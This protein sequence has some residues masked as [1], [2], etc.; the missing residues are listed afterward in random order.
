MYSEV[1][2]LHT[3][4]PFPDITRGLLNPLSKEFPAADLMIWM[5]C[6]IGTERIFEVLVSGKRQDRVS[7]TDRGCECFFECIEEIGA[8]DFNVQ[9]KL[10]EL[11]IDFLHHIRDLFVGDQNDSHKFHAAF[12]I[13]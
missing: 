12:R 2:C 13:N 10:I 11:L 8:E 3:T 6:E 4:V 5:G 7:R 9:L 1:V